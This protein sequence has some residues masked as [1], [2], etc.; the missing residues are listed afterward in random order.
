MFDYVTKVDFV[1]T[2]GDLF[3]DTC[4]LTFVGKFNRYEFEHESSYIL[5]EKKV[6]RVGNCLKM[7]E[8]RGNVYTTRGVLEELNNRIIDYKNARDGAKLAKKFFRERDNGSWPDLSHVRVKRSKD[9]LKTYRR[10][11][12]YLE[13]NSLSGDRGTKEERGDIVKF[14]KKRDRCSMLSLVD[15]GLLVDLIY[16]GSW[17]GL[18][19]ADIR[20]IE[21]YDKAFRYFSL[22]NCF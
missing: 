6:E 22:D 13:R 15:R 16:S 17:S 9:G 20:M 12:R 21:V 10:L 3:V 2:E 19:G 7:F 4:A 1:P 14:I 8:K 18:F 11:Y 5:N